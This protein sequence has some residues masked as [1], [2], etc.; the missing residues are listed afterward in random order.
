MPTF[1]PTA[2]FWDDWRRLTPSQRERF[3]RARDLFVADLLAG[4][5]FRPG[6]RVKSFRRRPGVYEMTWAP[7]GRALFRYGVSKQSGL[8]HIIWE[9]IGT[10]DIF[11]RP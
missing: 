1:E 10:H 7:D 9:A 6:L 8:P 11:T 5:G 2:R 3:L 4:R